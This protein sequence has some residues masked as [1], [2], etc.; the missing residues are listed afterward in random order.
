MG[1][2]SLP[3][4]LKHKIV[5]FLDTKSLLTLINSGQRDLDNNYIWKKKCNNEYSFYSNI[6]K[7]WKKKYKELYL[8]KCI[9]CHKNT[10]L[11]NDFFKVKIC[12]NCEINNI[13]YNTVTYTQAKKNYLLTNKEL[14]KLYFIR[15]VNPYN[16]TKKIKLYL[17]TDIINCITRPD[18]KYIQTI[19]QRI[20]I[21]RMYYLMRVNKFTLILSTLINVYN[22][23][24]INIINIMSNLNIYSKGL[25]K[26]FMRYNNRSPLPIINKALELD[27]IFTYTSIILYTAYNSFEDLLFNYLVTNVNT[28]LPVNINEYING[29][30]D[31]CIIKYRD[32]FIRKIEVLRI[33]NE[34]KH[35]LT[36]NNIFKIMAIQTYIRDDSYISNSFDKLYTQFNLKNYILLYDFLYVNT[37]IQL[38]IF[39]YNLVGEGNSK[40]NLLGKF[41]SKYNIFIIVLNEWYTK[42]PTL[43]YKIPKEL[44]PLLYY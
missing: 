28:L 35:R 1:I 40:Y 23:S 32:C 20:D 2:S 3:Y 6:I 39:Q 10:K 22:V 14:G 31:K 16:Y 42:N 4:E 30:I 8:T 25:Y 36:I 33:Y 44:Y 5:E 43:R 21:R 7:D 19:Q 34:L 26:K 24:E 27:F 13:K 12:R 9:H 37:D 41:I 15:R 17:K 18:G 38:I 11:F 29:C